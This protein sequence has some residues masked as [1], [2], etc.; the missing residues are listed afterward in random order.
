MAHM[1]SEFESFT[2]YENL[3]SEVSEGFR[4]YKTHGI[5]EVTDKQAEIT[6]EL[7]RDFLSLH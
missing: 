1:T 5:L 4:R 6:L 7:S 3:V 2:W